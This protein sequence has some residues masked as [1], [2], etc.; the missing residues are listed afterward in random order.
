VA[1]SAALLVDEVLP[2]KPIRQWVLTV[3]FPLHFLFAAFPEL[4]SKVLGIVTRALPLHLAHQAGLK[5]KEAYT[6]AVT[7]IQRFGSALNLNIYFHMFFKRCL[8]TRW[9]TR[10]RVS[11]QQSS[12]LRATH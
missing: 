7:L 11:L 12:Y 2:N 6:G 9:R 3:L 8:R 1:D 5:K 10:F 4:M